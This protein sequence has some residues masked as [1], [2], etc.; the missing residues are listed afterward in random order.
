[1]AIADRCAFYLC[2]ANGALFHHQMTRGGSLEYSDCDESAGYFGHCTRMVV[3]RLASGDDGVSEGVIT[4]VLG[5][6]CHDSSI[7]K[8]DRW[9][10]HMDGLH[11][12]V[13]LRHGFSG[14]S[15]HTQL[16]AFWLDVTGCAIHDVTPRFAVP[17]G[18]P[19]DSVRRCKPSPA[20][21]ATITVLASTMSPNLLQVCRALQQ[22]ALVA[23]FIKENAHKPQFRK[24]DIDAMTLLGPAAHAVLSIPRLAVNDSAIAYTGADI[25]CEVVRLA[26]LILIAGL[27]KAFSLNADELTVLQQKYE[28]L[29][30]QASRAFDTCPELGLWSML[31]VACS[32]PRLTLRQ[33]LITAIRDLMVESNVN[34]TRELTKVAGSIIW[35]ELL[36]DVKVESLILDM[37]NASVLAPESL[38]TKYARDSILMDS[39]ASN[40]FEDQTPQ[41]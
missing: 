7:A 29:L 10:V 6:L 4:T 13:Q 25:L 35:V 23:A 24:A 11:R 8:W 22:T 15:E 2:L 3:Q 12:I 1:M 21:T 33:S 41:R 9:S 18:L 20:L 36:M 26:L 14:L 27:K 40:L 37:Q 5:F 17:A 34:T 30:P 19:Q 39:I 38:S 28:G 16:L 31:V 32:D